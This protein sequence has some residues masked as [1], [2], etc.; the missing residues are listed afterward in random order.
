VVEEESAYQAW[1]EQQPTFKQ[2]SAQ[3]RNGTGEELIPVSSE[4]KADSAK[5]EFAR[6]AQD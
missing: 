5:R 6:E 4:G 2:L 1:L 3:A